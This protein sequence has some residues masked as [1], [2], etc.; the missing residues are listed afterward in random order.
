MLRK[1][2]LGVFGMFAASAGM[3]AQLMQIPQLPNAPF[4]AVNT[5]VL[6][7]GRGK[8]QASGKVARNSDGSIYQEQWSPDGGQLVQIY[9]IDVP[10]K[11]FIRLDPAQK[12]YT[13]REGP[14]I[15]A[16]APMPEL[17]EVI[18]AGGK[19]IHKEISGAAED[20]QPLGQKEMEGISVVG[21]STTA[22]RAAGRFGEAID[23]TT[24]KWI[25]PD[26]QIALVSK[27]HDVAKGTDFVS[28]LSQVKRGDPPPSLFHIPF[29]YEQ[30]PA[31]AKA[32]SAAPATEAPGK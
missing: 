11:K 9:I 1:L 16:Y 19:S 22:K 15:G 20:I 12:L 24:E 5:T 28:K 31:N 23:F 25:S 3:Q 2:L 27:T 26:L 13:V 30:D 18:A 10:A 29:D 4:Q 21:V 32:M 14:T 8:H 17:A 7:D 6:D